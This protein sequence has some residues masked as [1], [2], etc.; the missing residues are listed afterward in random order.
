VLLQSITMEILMKICLRNTA[1]V[2]QIQKTPQDLANVLTSLVTKILQILKKSLPNTFTGINVLLV[3][4][5]GYV[6]LAWNFVCFANLLSIFSQRIFRE[7]Y[8][9]FGAT[10]AAFVFPFFPILV[11]M[12]ALLIVSAVQFIIPCILWGV[13]VVFTTFFVSRSDKPLLVILY[14]V[15][16]LVFFVYCLYII[17]KNVSKIV[18]R[19]KGQFFVWTVSFSKIALILLLGSVGLGVW[20]CVIVKTFKI[21]DLAQNI[22]LTQLEKDLLFWIWLV[23]KGLNITINLLVRLLRFLQRRALSKLFDAIVLQFVLTE[24]V[25]LLFGFAGRV[26]FLA[27]YMV[28]NNETFGLS[29]DGIQNRIKSLLESPPEEGQEILFLIDYFVLS[30]IKSE[31]SVQH[32]I[33]IL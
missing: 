26:L 22:G 20:I 12:I 3:S 16:T 11:L 27:R 2:I 7:G 13:A 6:S 8:W 9:L 29:A 14:G 25:A 32:L 24:L 33:D 18:R 5:L 4:G 19:T 17:G 31:R 21:S 1:I 30:Y 10:C 15:E 28:L 23:S